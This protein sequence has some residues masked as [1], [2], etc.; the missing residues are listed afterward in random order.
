MEPDNLSLTSKVAVSQKKCPHCG[1]WTV[2]NQGM[3]DTC[4]HCGHLLSTHLREKEARAKR[5]YEAPK[6][7]FPVQATDG[8]FLRIGKQTLNVTHIAFMALV[9]F[10]MWFVTVVAS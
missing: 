6:G 2:W 1:Q 9:S 8:L 10:V 4:S 7:L 3:D 5:I